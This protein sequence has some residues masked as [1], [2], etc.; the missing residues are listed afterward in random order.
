MNDEV[1]VNRP[2]NSNVRSDMS[3]DGSS[4]RRGGSKM[5]WIV[6]AVVVIIVVVLAVLF[7]DR[8]AGKSDDK[9]T[10]KSSD[11]QAVF[12]TNGQVYF[13]RISNTH[14]EYVTLK[15]IFYLQV[16][17]PP[18]QGSQ[19]QQQAQQAQPQLSL[20]KLGNE[21]HGPVDEMHI[22]RTQILFYEDMKADGKVA[23]AIK[24]YKANPNGTG[25][26]NGAQGQATPP[27]N[28]QQ[29]APAP[30]A[31]PAPAGNNAT[32]QNSNQGQTA[33]KQ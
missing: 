26:N 6:L 16:Q 17:N 7:R 25:N 4:P 27:A 12:L 8:W 29:Q 18:I 24:E 15:D 33:P 19:Q 5:P 32:Q 22:N 14:E 31:A 10:G 9:M 30:A 23:Q 20:V 28:Q 1:R 21:L 2:M 11:Y 13:G 3:G